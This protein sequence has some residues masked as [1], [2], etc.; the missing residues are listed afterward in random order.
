MKKIIVGILVLVAIGG[1]VWWSIQSKPTSADLTGITQTPGQTINPN[2]TTTPSGTSIGGYKDGSYNGQSFSSIYGP[3]QV[4][5][6][7]S[8]G[9]LTAV[10]ILQEPTGLGHSQEV[11]ARAIPTLQQE[12]IA[13][14]SANVDIVS[15]A[16]QDSEAFQQSLQ[17][18][19]QLA[20]Q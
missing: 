5:V 10:N 7:I 3:I 19:L 15:G 13:S 16:T 4:A 9:K 1:Y 18:A 6:V 8:G 11:A 14:Q 17:S 12:A 20:A 2:G